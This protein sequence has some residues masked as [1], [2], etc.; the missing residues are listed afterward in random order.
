[1]APDHMERFVRDGYGFIT[2][3]ADAGFLRQ[4]AASEIAR[5][6]SIAEPV[7]RDAQ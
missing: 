3:G 2:I 7:G 1:M 4:G 6:R 5:L